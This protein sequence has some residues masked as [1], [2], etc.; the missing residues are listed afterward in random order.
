M[1]S[2]QFNAKQAIGAVFLSENITAPITRTEFDALEIPGYDSMYFRRIFGSWDRG[3]RMILDW[4]ADKV[5]LAPTVVNALVNQTVEEGAVLTYAFAANSFAAPASEAEQ[6]LTYQMVAAP[7]WL[8]FTAGT[9]TITGIA[10]EVDEETVQTV[11]I[12]ALDN[13]GRYVDASF[14]VTITVA[15]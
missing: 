13:Y 2:R 7:E 9:R 3:M 1:G 5:N 15:A 8:S 10:P 11:T 14:T 6:T 4:T 12:R